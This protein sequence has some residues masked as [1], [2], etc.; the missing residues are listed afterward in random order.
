M[1]APAGAAGAGPAAN[2]GPGMG[3]AGGV[4]SAAGA[5]AGCRT[6]RWTVGGTE[7]G[8]GDSAV[9]S[10]TGGKGR[11]AEGGAGVRGALGTLLTGAES[12]G[13]ALMGAPSGERRAGAAGA[14]G[15]GVVASVPAGASVRGR[16]PGGVADR[17][18]TGAPRPGRGARRL[19]PRRWTTGTG[20]GA[21]WPEV[22]AGRGAVADA[23]GCGAAVGPVAAGGV[24]LAALRCTGV[25]AD[26]VCGVPLLR[27][28]AVAGRV[29]FA[30][31]GAGVSAVRVGAGADAVAGEAVVGRCGAAGAVAGAPGSGVRPLWD[32]DVRRCTAPWTP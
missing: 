13:S 12:V 2:A 6:L 22:A 26:G 25:S 5:G 15:A 7:A 20:A 19:L 18:D 32:G 11:A 14:W 10:G 23:V 16:G 27:V 4:G 24:E 28:G 8:R 3:A 31:G 1:G 17:E 9:G 30:R 29:S 21:F